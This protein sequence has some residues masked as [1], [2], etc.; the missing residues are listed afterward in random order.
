[1]TA[2][3][4]GANEPLLRAAA[5]EEELVVLVGSSS[6]HGS[7]ISCWASPELLL[8]WREPAAAPM[9]FGH[10]YTFITPYLACPF[11]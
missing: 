4:P 8:L 11:P 1:M 6:G 3:L 10:Y 9:Q 7:R 5:A 2:P